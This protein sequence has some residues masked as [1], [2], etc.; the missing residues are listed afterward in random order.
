V[1]VTLILLTFKLP[2]FSLAISRVTLNPLSLYPQSQSQ[3]LSHFSHL[4]HLSSSSIS[5]LSSFSVLL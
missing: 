4:Q 1:T 2:L 5:S 3:S